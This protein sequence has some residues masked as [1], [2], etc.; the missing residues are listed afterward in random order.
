M[1]RK[2]SLGMRK[3]KPKV[4][5]QATV[6]EPAATDSAVE[7]SAASS[8]PKPKIKESA[9][10]V[11][12]SPGKQLRLAAGR[13]VRTAREK[14]RAAERHKPKA[15]DAREVADRVYIAKKMLLKGGR[16][17]KRGGDKIQ[18]M[19]DRHMCEHEYSHAQLMWLTRV[20]VLSELEVIVK[21]AGL[22]LRDAKIAMLQRRLRVVKKQ[23]RG[24]KLGKFSI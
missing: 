24:R 11:P 21:D 17:K 16:S 12:P 22:A 13:A 14:L 7:E 6:T 19:H 3:S 8:P 23:R 20:R 18:R 9:A 15:Y 1:G 10:Q 5:A 4:V 2:L